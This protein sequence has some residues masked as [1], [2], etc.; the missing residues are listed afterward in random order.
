MF[1]KFTEANREAWNEVMP[2]HQK[3]ASDRWDN[4]FKQPGYVCLGETELYLL[5]QMGIEGKAVAQLCCNNGVELLSLK[6]LGAGECVGFDISD[7]A[8]R[9]TRER[10]EKCQIDCQF[11]RSDVYEIGSEYENRFN[12]VY[13]S[14]G[15]L[16]WMPDLKKF[17]A[18]A[19]ALLKVNGHV[20][21]HEIHPFSE[22]LP[23]DDAEDE[24][25]LR[26]VDP[27]FKKEP[28]IDYGRLDYVGG[29]QYTS[30]KPQYWFVHTLSDILM[31]L[32]E[33][34]IFVEFFS[35]YEK[36]IS[37]VHKRVESAQAG[38]PLS[39]ILIG[40]KGRAN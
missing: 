7:V 23:F 19:A 13:I 12:L 9:E 3:A 15:A 21:S 35:E 30:A 1:K 2:M 29:E 36:D 18:K 10:A 16:G 28:Y 40:R 27:Y 32:I 17:F 38:I 6:N 5:K 26:I 14:S 37:S 8:I 25:A 33:N 34:Q 22:M 24:D 20:F 11:V 31:G 39:T 4:A